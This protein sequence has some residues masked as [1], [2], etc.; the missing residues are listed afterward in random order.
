MSLDFY[1]GESGEWAS[2]HTHA[3]V[4]MN[5]VASVGNVALFMGADGRLDA[6]AL[7]GNC[8]AVGG[9]RATAV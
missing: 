7:D 3:P 1:D 5:G 9:I 2:T 4:T 8:S 6:I